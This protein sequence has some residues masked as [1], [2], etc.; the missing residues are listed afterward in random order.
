MGKF[1]AV[2]ARG[3]SGRGRSPGCAATPTPP[4]LYLHSRARQPETFDGRRANWRETARRGLKRRHEA[5]FA[6]T[7]VAGF[8]E[9]LRKVVMAK[10]HWPVAIF[11]LIHVFW[12]GGEGRGLSN[13]WPSNWTAGPVGANERPALRAE[14]QPQSHG[15]EAGVREVDVYLAGQTPPVRPLKVSLWHT[16]GAL[17]S[18]A[19]QRAGKGVPAAPVSQCSGPGAE[20]LGERPASLDLPW[21]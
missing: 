20:L 3:G 2:C 17:K 4:E 19:S 12:Q 21:P 9:R 5:A 15:A 16:R 18:T 7:A 11:F 6:V 14:S 10:S 13:V 1:T 8:N